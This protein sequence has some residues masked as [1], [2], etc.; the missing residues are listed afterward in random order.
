MNHTKISH[1]A[2]VAALDNYTTM[3]RKLGKR[4]Y[5]HAA[6]KLEEM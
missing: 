3:I 2:R 5:P 4:C 6:S 1:E